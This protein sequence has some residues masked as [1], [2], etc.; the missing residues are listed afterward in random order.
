[1]I[2]VGATLTDEIYMQ[3][4]RAAQGCIARFGPSPII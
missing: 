4:Y 1:M 2:V 3:Q